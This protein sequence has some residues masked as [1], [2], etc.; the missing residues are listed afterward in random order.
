MKPYEIRGLLTAANYPPRKV[1]ES[2]GVT[3]SMVRQVITRAKVS[4][5]I[6]LLISEIIGRDVREV[7]P[8]SAHLFDV[9]SNSSSRAWRAMSNNAAQTGRNVCGEEAA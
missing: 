1:A 5:R 8:E 7:F 4:A 3:P 6:M 2:M 9:S